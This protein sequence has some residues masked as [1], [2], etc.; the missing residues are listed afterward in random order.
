MRSTS[1]LRYLPT[2]IALLLIAGCAKVSS[3]TGGPR[4]ITPPKVLK[5]TP[6]DGTT[7]FS[8]GTVTVTFDEYFILEKI[9]DKFM[10]SPPTEEKPEIKIKGKELIISLKGKLKDSTTY[11]FYFQDAIRDNNERNP[12]PNFQYVL[13]T[14]TYVDSLSVTGNA[15]VSDNLEPAS[16]YLVG[17]FSNLSDTAVF[18]TLPDY[19][20]ISD[21]SGNFRINNVKPGIFNLSA[22]EDKNGD[23]KYTFPEESFG[24]LSSTVEITP[25]KNWLP[26]VPDT[27]PVKPL[28][29]GPAQGS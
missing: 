26:V 12:I 10:V 17:L 25:E 9:D 24:Y 19:I 22:F 4:D 14:G 29:P 7:L 5:I 1:L 21:A 15:F 28:P 11:T 2:I 3:P 13:S 8:S 27:V 6:P 23:K 16:G 18:T 20:T